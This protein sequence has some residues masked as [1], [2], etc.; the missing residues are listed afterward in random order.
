MAKAVFGL[1]NSTAHADRIIS[2]LQ[3]AG[4]RYEDI[5]ILFSD[6]QGNLQHSETTD[7]RANAS[8]YDTTTNTSWSDANRSGT[9][10]DIP[11]N[12]PQAGSG[13]LGVEKNTKAPEGGVAGATAGGII[14]G[15]LGLL[16]GLGALAIPGLGPFVA[17]GPLMAALSGSAIGGALGLLAGTLVGMGIPEMEAKKYEN[18]LKSGSVLLAVT[19]TDNSQTDKIKKIMEQEGAKDVTSS[20]ESTARS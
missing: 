16:A 20:S 4:F 19:V 8:R 3:E 12:R 17:A 7:P 18:Q 6:K 2:R 10:K 1:A 9:S 13:S 15:S 11:H 14:G 5:S